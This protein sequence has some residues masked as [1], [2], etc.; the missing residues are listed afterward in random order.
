VS[1][2]PPSK[3]KRPLFEFIGW[4]PAVIIPAATVFGLWNA[5]S[6]DNPASMGAPSWFVFGVANVCFYIYTEK[7]RS[8]Q[9]ILGF[10]GTAVLDF[11]IVAVVLI[12]T[13]A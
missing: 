10:L 4:V 1:D 7:Y 12:R 8:P 5:I 3:P 11:I 2:P 13:A 9:A 6:T